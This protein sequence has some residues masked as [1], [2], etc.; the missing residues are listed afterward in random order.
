MTNSREALE[1]IKETL[2]DH[3]NYSFALR[4][5]PKSDNWAA[6]FTFKHTWCESIHLNLNEAVSAACDKMYDLSDA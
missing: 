2:E 3:P 4:Y 1:K 6:R 5:F